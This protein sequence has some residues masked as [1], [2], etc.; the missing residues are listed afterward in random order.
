MIGADRLSLSIPISVPDLPPHGR[1]AH[2]A[3]AGYRVLE[4]WWPWAAPLPSAGDRQRLI[5]A[6][7]AADARLHLLNLTEGPAE[8]GGRG[9]AGRAGG[10]EAFAAHASAVVALAA[11]LGGRWINALAG[12]TGPEGAGAGRAVLRERVLAV[13]ALG[14]AADVGVVLEPLNRDDHPDYLLDPVEVPGLVRELREAGAD[15]ALLADVYHLARAGVDPAGF[16]REHAGLI[17][18]VQLADHPGRGRPGSGAI[19]FPA[20]LRALDDTGY[21][22]MI[23]LEH[24]P[25]GALLPPDAAWRALAAADGATH[26]E[27]RR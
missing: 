10:D 12:N 11:D 18:H 5:D 1:V 13:A 20:V 24:R 23:G 27:A 9:I 3:A 26:E 16:L 6:F 14:A 22:G 15:V 19:D 4:S 17:G 2:A 21:A 8:A 7:R 25:G